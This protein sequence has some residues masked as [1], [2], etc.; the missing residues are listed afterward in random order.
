MTGW[1]YLAVVIDL[2]N[3]EVIGYDISKKSDTELTKQALFQYIELFYNR[4]RMHSLLGDVSPVSY[5]GNFGF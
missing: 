3:R 1:V 2:F 4:K 5:R